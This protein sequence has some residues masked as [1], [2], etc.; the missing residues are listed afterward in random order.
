[1]VRRFRFWTFAATA[2]LL[3]G[4][5]LFSLQGCPDGTVPDTRLA[6]APKLVPPARS[7]AIPTPPALPGTIDVGI[8]GPDTLESGEY[9]KFHVLGLTADDLRKARPICWPRDKTVLVDSKT[10]QDDPFLWFQAHVAGQY[11]VQVVAVKGGE[12]AYG[13]KI[14][15]VGTSPVPPV[16]VSLNLA[17]P[18]GVVEGSS[19][20]GTI[21]VIGTSQPVQVS[22]NSS[23][24]ARLQ[25]PAS[26]T[27]T[28]SGSFPLSAPVTGG[29]DVTVTVVAAVGTATAQGTVLVTAMGPGPAPT[30]LM[31]VIVR[32][33]SQPSAE[34][35]LVIGSQRLREAFGNRF[36]VLDVTQ[37]APDAQP[38]I[39]L[40]RGKTLPYFITVSK[41]TGRVYRQGTLPKTVDE[42][43]TWSK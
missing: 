22:L 11:L 24:P 8:D 15:Q 20:T 4:A 3:G 2:G 29:Q 34:Y 32:D 40:A 39:A 21:T 43:I 35:A 6:A 36:R 19:G 25:V 33:S 23:F 28:G 26:V 31:G 7:D 13:E 42:A 9:G 18:S 27:V 14:V 30:D 17:V 37:P 10:W 12:L 1:M 41:S 16:P 5:V 38:Y